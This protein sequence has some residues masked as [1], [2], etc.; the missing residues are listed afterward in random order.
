MPPNHPI[1]QVQFLQTFLLFPMPKF[2][3]NSWQFQMT[4]EVEETLLQEICAIMQNAFQNC[5]KWKQCRDS[6]GE[7]YEGDKFRF[8]WT[9]HVC[10]LQAEI[11]I[12]HIFQNTSP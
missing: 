7:Y 1:L 10:F 11:Q 5:K 4:E 9:D 8:F 3:L 6:G 12:T 2:T